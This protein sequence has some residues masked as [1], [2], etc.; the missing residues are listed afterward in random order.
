MP[1][2]ARRVIYTMSQIPDAILCY[3]FLEKQA[4]YLTGDI[5]AA[6]LLQKIR[7]TSE[8]LSYM[9]NR[10]LLIKRKDYTY[11]KNFKYVKK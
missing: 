7:V 9:V 5:E 6:A 3:S 10:N 4:Y 2:A 1:A 8:T 11:I